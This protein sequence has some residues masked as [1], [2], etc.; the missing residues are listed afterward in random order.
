[1]VDAANRLG[2][3]IDHAE[4]PADCWWQR[5]EAAINEMTEDTYNQE[6]A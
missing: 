1:M 6:A 4:H 2:I 3:A 5:V